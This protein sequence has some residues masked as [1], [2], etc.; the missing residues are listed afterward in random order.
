VPLRAGI[1][2]LR[3]GGTGTPL[4][5]LRRFADSGPG[6]PIARLQAGSWGSLQLP[7]DPVAEPWLLVTKVPVTVCSRIN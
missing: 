7:A 2:R 4:I 5:G 1:T 6:V 3:V